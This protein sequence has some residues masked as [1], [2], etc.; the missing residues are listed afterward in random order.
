MNLQQKRQRCSRLEC[1][2][3]VKENYFVSKTYYATRGVA[4]FLQ[5]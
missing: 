5:R 3:K 4:D 2:Y 1:F